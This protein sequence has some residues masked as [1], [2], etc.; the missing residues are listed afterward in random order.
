M[1]RYI[2]TGA[3]GAGK[4]S[5]MRALHGQGYAV[6]DEAATDIITRGLSRRGERPRHDA[7]FIEAIALLQQARQQRQAPPGTA[8][9]LYDRSP[10]CTLALAHY[11]GQ[12]VP[13]TLAG[14]VNRVLR[15][16]TYQ[17]QV[18]F[19]RLLGFVTRTAV[20]RITF[21]QTVEFERV[22]EQVY[23]AHGY[24]LVDVP[25]G[26]VAER[27]ALIDR[28]LRSWAKPR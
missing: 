2:I 17:P 20:R 16:R 13:E 4:T 15:E 22:H 14:E 6:V 21:E 10:I 12:Q 9:Q 7:G 28:Y 23:R 8:V 1:L 5:I 19:V 3:P 11:I 24:E 26:T 27:A 25:A 18:F